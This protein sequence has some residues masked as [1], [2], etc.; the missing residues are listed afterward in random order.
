MSSDQTQAGTGAA[1]GRPD[2]PGLPV[3]RQL[4]PAP[5]MF[6]GREDDLEALEDTLGRA[7]T[8]QASPVVVIT[9]PDGIGKRALAAAWGR[10]LA[11]RYPD[12]QLVARLRA[13]TPGGPAPVSEVT[14]ALLRSLGLGDHAPLPGTEEDLVRLW[15][16]EAARR[17]AL[18]LLEDAA[19]ADQVRPLIPQKVLGN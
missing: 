3:P 16:T 13:R 2:L 1:D 12:G 10:R 18:V 19:N 17:N 6:T 8:A 14:R 11:D 7:D 4:A 15:Q 9:G 5:P